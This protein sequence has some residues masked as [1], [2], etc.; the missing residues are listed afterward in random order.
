VVIYSN[1]DHV[2]KTAK[3]LSDTL[4]NSSARAY[5]AWAVLFMPVVH[6]ALRAFF[7]GNRIERVVV[8]IKT[9]EEQH[10]TLHQARW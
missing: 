3:M 1:C 4:T 6:F 9:L 8:D 7:I 10:G 2:K 5:L